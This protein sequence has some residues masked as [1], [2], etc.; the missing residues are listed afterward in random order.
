MDPNQ[1]YY[2][3]GQSHYFGGGVGESNIH[4]FLLA[5]LM[6]AAAVLMFAPRKL[7]IYAF[8]LG[9]ILVPGW[10]VIVFAGVH[11]QPL[12]VLVGTGCVRI[13]KSA[14]QPTGVFNRITW[15]TLD[16]V[17]VFWAASSVVTF[18]LLWGEWG[19][20]TN[21]LG[22]LFNYLGV[23]F[24]F[25]FLIRDEKDQVRAVV[26][27]LALACFACGLL[28]VSEQFLGHK[29]YAMFGGTDPFLNFREGRPR[30][31]ASFMHPLLAGAFGGTLVPL[32]I[33]EWWQRSRTRLIATLGIV[34]ALMMVVT[35]NTS[36]S[37]TAVGSGILALCLWPVRRGMRVVRWSL[38]IVLTTLHLVMKAPVW[39]LIARIDLTGG[40]SGYHRF[41]LI[42]QAIRHFWDWWLVGTTT[43]A[44]WGWDMWDSIDWYVSEGTSGGLLTLALFVAIIVYAFKII[45][46]ARR[47]AYLERD[48]RNEFFLWSMGASV[49]ANVLGFI[50]IAYYDQSIVMW[51]ALL[52]MISGMRVTTVR[53]GR[54][55]E[56]SQVV[57][58][59]LVAIPK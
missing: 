42:D 26:Q 6:F 54:R 46:S 55:S 56:D 39:A 51:L 17:V 27:A 12:R 59:E 22:E 13:L 21:K 40:S 24:L 45:G 44:S 10:Q 38:V 5:V 43:Q 33:G 50:G 32:F 11:V 1:Q 4:P 18:S 28:M 47:Q 31:Q 23:Y 19:A 20:F 35:S 9:A 14:M 41:E 57:H 53:R 30:S 29:A 15:K 37:L 2:Q 25:R 3:G 36:T 7:A 34:G 49:F 8:V 52:A 58:S 48:H 16:K